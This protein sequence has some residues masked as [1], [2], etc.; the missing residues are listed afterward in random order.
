MHLWSLLETFW[1]ISLLWYV[2]MYITIWL[3]VWCF[4]MLRRQALLSEILRIFGKLKVQW[5]T[6]I[7][8]LNVF[9]GYIKL[10]PDKFLLHFLFLKLW[11]S[12]P[13]KKPPLRK[14]FPT[15][16]GRYE[17]HSTKSRSL[18]IMHWL[19]LNLRSMVSISR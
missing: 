15:W 17:I 18:C 6:Y 12:S 9:K 1:G 19:N 10:R 8:S 4:S 2:R 3:S 5:T 13:Y 14:Y 16:W 11:V 7:C